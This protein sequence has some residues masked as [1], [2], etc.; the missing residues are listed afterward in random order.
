MW[1]STTPLAH[2]C[3]NKVNTPLSA[4]KSPT[5]PRPYKQ[6]KTIRDV[7]SDKQ[8]TALSETLSCSFACRS[9]F[10]FNTRA[11][12]DLA[13]QKIKTAPDTDRLGSLK[14][15]PF[16]PVEGHGEWEKSHIR[17]K[18]NQ[19]SKPPIFGGDFIGRAHEKAR[20]AN[21]QRG[22]LAQW[23]LG[24]VLQKPY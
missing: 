12:I 7:R 10:C 22:F 15:A 14:A 13:W 18:T 21:Q 23:M 9:Y 20:P 16:P 1:V 17:K 24:N 4:H 3:Q 8:K 19:L 6:T 2:Q 11:W 5:L